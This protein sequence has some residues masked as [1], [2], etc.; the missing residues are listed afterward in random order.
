[1]ALPAQSRPAALPARGARRS[2]RTI[3]L[4]GIDGSGKTTQ[5][6]GLAARLIADGFPAA[7]RQNAGGRHWFGRIA[8]LLGRADAEDLFGR[9][10]TLAVESALR[11]LAIARTLLRRAVRREIAVMDRYAVCQF[12]S[13]RAHGARPAA[14][15]FARLAYRLFP[16]PDVTFFLAVDPEIAQERIE[17]R[18]Y[19]HES[20]EYLRAATDAYR[21][22]P[23]YSRFIVI[24]ANGTPD[25]VLKALRT[26]LGLDQA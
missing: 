2:P 20:I 19:D 14:E 17:R 3:A 7:Y 13:L 1:M 11:W 18:G 9:R 15:R 26:E 10:G 24:D 22:L 6:R 16:R 23:E 8:V 4:V 5:A 25:Q 21:S 12:A